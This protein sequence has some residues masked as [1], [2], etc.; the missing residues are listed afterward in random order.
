MELKARDEEAEIGGGRS[1]GESEGHS[2]HDHDQVDGN[3]F[4]AE[5]VLLLVHVRFMCTF[6]VAV[7]AVLKNLHYDSRRFVARRYLEL[8]K[9]I[10]S[11]VYS[12][13]I[14][15]DLMEIK[16]ELYAIEDRIDSCQRNVLRRTKARL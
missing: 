11:D 16:P 12:S 8:D 9:L 14:S 10:H 7:V 5:I 3:A 15:E 4:F 2:K 6:L 13:S 1:G